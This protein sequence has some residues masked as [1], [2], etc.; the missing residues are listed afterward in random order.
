MRPITPPPEE[1][2]TANVS[3]GVSVQYSHFVV[4]GLVVVASVYV[5]TWVFEVGRLLYVVARVAV[6]A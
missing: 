5:V 6:V 2:N 1:N 4:A 3:N